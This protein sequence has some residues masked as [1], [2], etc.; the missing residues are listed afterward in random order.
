[1]DMDHLKAILKPAE[2]ALTNLFTFSLRVFNNRL[3]AHCQ[4]ESLSDIVYFH[5]FLSL[6][7]T[8]RSLDNIE[9]ILNKDIKGANCQ[10]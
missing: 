1:M 6:F 2:T 10:D 5:Y 7:V 4:L 3:S 8:F 9:S